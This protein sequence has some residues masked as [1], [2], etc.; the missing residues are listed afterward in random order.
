MKCRSLKFMDK[1]NNFVFLFTYVKIKKFSNDKSK[2]N[3]QHND[4]KKKYKRIAA[5]NLQNAT[6]KPKDQRH[7]LKNRG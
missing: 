7:C 5:N 3:R 2:M 6:Q 4:K 1:D